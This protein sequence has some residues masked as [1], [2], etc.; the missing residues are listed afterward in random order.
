MDECVFMRRKSSSDGDMA[1][2]AGVSRVAFMTGGTP[3]QGMDQVSAEAN[4]TAKTIAIMNDIHRFSRVAGGAVAF[5][6]G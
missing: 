5:R 4:V 1:L 2:G 3:F 6:V